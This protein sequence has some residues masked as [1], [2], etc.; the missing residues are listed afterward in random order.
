[1]VVSDAVR[2]HHAPQIVGARVV[3]QN[4]VQSRDV[5]FCGTQN[6][7]VRF[8]TIGF[9][10]FVVFSPLFAAALSLRCVVAT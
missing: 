5:G 6:A 1:M 7:N 4:G 3:G 10:L 2:T 9:A 8:C